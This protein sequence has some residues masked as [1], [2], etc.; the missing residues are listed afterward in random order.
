MNEELKTYFEQNI[1]NYSIK[2]LK[3]ECIKA[4]H[5]EI[6]INSIINRINNNNDK[7]SDYNNKHNSNADFSSN[8][9]YSKHNLRK[10]YLTGFTFILLAIF[11]QLEQYFISDYDW[12]FLILFV[13]GA[14]INFTHS[15]NHINRDS[16]DR[17][18]ISILIALMGSIYVIF[19][20]VLL[21]KFLI[22]IILY[23]NLEFIILHISR[24]I[25]GIF[26]L[27]TIISVIYY[28]LNYV[29]LK[30]IEY[31]FYDNVSNSK[32]DVYI[33]KFDKNYSLIN[34]VLIVLVG[35]GFVILNDNSI[36]HDLEEGFHTVQ[37]SIDTM[38][39]P[40]NGDFTG[41]NK[42]YF[43]DFDIK[44]KSISSD[45][46]NS[47]SV[48]E[49]KT[50]SFDVSNLFTVEDDFFSPLDLYSN[51]NRFYEL[52]QLYSA[53]R[54]LEEIYITNSFQSIDNDSML[55]NSS[56]H[57]NDDLLILYA[58]LEIQLQMSDTNITKSN[59][60]P[61]RI[62]L[63]EVFNVPLIQLIDH[64]REAE[65]VKLREEVTKKF[66]DNEV[67][68][69]DYDFLSLYPI[70][71]NSFYNLNTELLYQSYLLSSIQQQSKLF[72]NSSTIKDEVYNI[73]SNTS[74][75]IPNSLLL[76]FDT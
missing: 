68:I 1:S 32:T 65:A 41:P 56:Q 47:L 38:A 6:E 69:R 34:L 55:L 35:I 12:I 7:N 49:N 58:R 25:Q 11:F 28:V 61:V 33:N 9:K 48:I 3:N 75:I 53:Q 36:R 71:M 4:G 43:S 73:Y 30:F 59:Q 39:S 67:N 64:I 44:K 17:L 57:I 20:L 40:I 23:F 51:E 72:Q 29:N 19:F 18:L 76:L 45:L 26:L 22:L 52:Q 8:H 24:T 63:N 60:I 46:T 42:L 14:I 66:L 54:F 10:F 31:L 15:K 62:Q 5:S 13:L 21:G 74:I 70:E 27:A 16:L 50:I 2:E 37:R